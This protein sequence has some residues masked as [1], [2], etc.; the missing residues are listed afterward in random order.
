MDLWRIPSQGGAAERLTHHRSNIGWPT[1]IDDRTLLYTEVGQDGAAGLYAMDLERRIPHR[2]GLG[3]EEYLSLASSADGRRLAATVANPTH[4]LWTAPISDQVVNDSGLTNF[5]LSTTHVGAPR[6][7]PDYVVFLSSRGGPA[8]L[9]KFKDGSE[10]ELWNGNLGAIAGAP[11]VSRDGAQI[12]FVVREQGRGVLHVMASDGTNVHR[13][14]DTLD[15]RDTPSWSPDGKWIAA[16]VSEAESRPLFKVAADGGQPL[17]LVDGML[18]DPVWSPDGRFILYSDGSQG[19]PT[20]TLRAVTPDKQPVPLPELPQVGYAGN[21]YRFLGDGKSLILMRGILW[22]QNFFR[23]DLS[24]G[25]LRQL[26]DLGPQYQIRSF[27][28]SPDGKQILFD[29]YRENSD[30]VLIDLPPR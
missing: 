7:G 24:T 30:I 13:V 15:V 23:V 17:R 27:D 20:V 22:R 8:G 12:A 10:T 11:A 14:A 5:R 25:Q 3:V 26:T 28:V 18:F 19:G 9:W 6:F 1:L 4:L 21:R 16:V 29:R 2:A